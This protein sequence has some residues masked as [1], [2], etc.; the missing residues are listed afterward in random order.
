MSDK[1]KRTITL[2]GRSPVRITDA[3]WPIIA[4]A[5]DEDWD[6]EFDFQANRKWKWFVGVRRHEDGRAIV[7]ATYSHTSQYRDER[8]AEARRGILIDETDDTDDPIITR[9]IEDVCGQMAD[10]ESPE[11]LQSGRWPALAAE[12]VA[13]LPAVEL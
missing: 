7:Y 13:D 1:R 3:E 8:D 9:T 5:S 2:T 10:V 4:S 12:C 6:G 11:N